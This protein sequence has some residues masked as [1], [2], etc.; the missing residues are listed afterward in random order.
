[1]TLGE[2]IRQARLEAGLSQRQL[3]GEEVT[4]NMLSQIENGTAKPSMDTLRY[5]AQRLG[6][7]VSF[8]LE[9]EAVCS[10]NQ[11]R[12]AAAREAYSAG[13]G[14][15]V[16][17]ILSAYRGPDPVFDLEAE[18][19]GRMGALLAARK[20]L[21]KGQAALAAEYLEKE[22][23]WNGGY[24]AEGLERQR[25]LLLAKA[26]PKLLSRIC[27]RLPSL[28]QELLLRARLALEEGNGQRCLQLLEAAQ[29]RDGSQW[30]F[31]RGQL[32]LQGREYA[33]AAQCLRRAEAEFPEKC[34]PLLETCYR[35]L[36]DF[37]QAYYY[38]CKR[39]GE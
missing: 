5:F 37:R 15:R 36:G 16:L 12:M 32:Y 17:E 30:N 20:A 28:D 31:L 4:R 7:S 23:V 34:A 18:L 25:L 9:E 33:K 27:A 1:M 29:D 21:D 2:K 26:R 10:P 13:D 11:E 35:E 24:C 3:C 8:F 38:A 14:V 19:L 6:K 39:R 22:M